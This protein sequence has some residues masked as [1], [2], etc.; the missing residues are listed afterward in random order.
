MLD[1]GLSPAAFAR[2]QGVT[3]SYVTRL[4]RLNFLA[5]RIIESIVSGT[6]PAVLD[7]KTLLG[8]SDLPL[9]WSRQEDLLLR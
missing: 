3:S 4:V 8:Q 7:A 5:P 1:R 2:E 6:Q 9:D